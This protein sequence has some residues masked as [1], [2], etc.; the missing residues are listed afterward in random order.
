LVKENWY[1][2]NSNYSFSPFSLI[3]HI[4]SAMLPP[5]LSVSWEILPFRWISREKNNS[6]VLQQMSFPVSLSIFL[7]N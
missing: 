1:I 4:S 3:W 2:E 7:L 6:N 5:L